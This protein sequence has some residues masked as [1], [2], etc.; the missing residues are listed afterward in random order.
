[1][2]KPKCL[3]IE[4][5]ANSNKETARYL[6]STIIICF[7]QMNIDQPASNRDSNLPRIH[8]FICIHIC[9]YIY[10]YINTYFLRT[11]SSSL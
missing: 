1:M 10:V 11:H 9:I 7:V 8:I 5:Y 2:N 4:S 3:S 6:F